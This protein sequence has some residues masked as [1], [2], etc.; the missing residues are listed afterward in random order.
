ML[1]TTLDAVPSVR[2]GRRERPRRRSDKL[3]ADK[4][5]DHLRCR[6][7]CRARGITL[8]IARRGIE[9]SERFGRYCWIFERTLAWLVRFRRPT[10]RDV[11]RA[12]IHLAFTTLACV[13]ICQ[14][15]TK[16]FFP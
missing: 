16:Q 13:L 11:R 9:S 1:A 8:R 3:H 4:A 12:D 7:E 14:A 5:Y 10:I 15:Q 2:T 6:C